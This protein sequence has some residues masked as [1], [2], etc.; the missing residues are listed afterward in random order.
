[1]Q[2]KKEATAIDKADPVA[3][4]AAKSVAHLKSVVVPGKPNAD[5]V[6]A[7]ILAAARGHDA[8]AVLDP[9]IAYLK[10][11]AKWPKEERIG[12]GYALAAAERHGKAASTD[13]EAAAKLVTADQQMDGSYG[14]SLFDSWRARATL[15]ASGVQPDEVWIILIDRWVR[16]LTVDTVSDA[17]LLLLALDLAGD[18]MAEDLRRKALGLVRSRH[19]AALAEASAAKPP[20]VFE[21]ALVVL[22]LGM[23]DAEPRMA[24]ASYRPEELKDAIARG[25]AALAAAQRPDG[26]W[27]GGVRDSAW[28][29]MALLG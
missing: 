16:G 23:L 21:T 28:A 17:A 1:M 25:K 24:R 6:R 11:P 27:P 2:L 19:T 20:A 26:S 15:V 10:Q 8:G 22:A 14:G 9:V 18:V 12:L 5:A 4:A 3:A 13:L 29:L 7:L